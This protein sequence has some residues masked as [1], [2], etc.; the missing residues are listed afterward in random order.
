MGTALSRD[1]SGTYRELGHTSPKSTSGLAIQQL[2][3]PAPA[4]PAQGL[5]DRMP[6]GPQ[7]DDIGVALLRVVQWIEAG[8]RP[9]HELTSAVLADP[10]IT[11]KLIRAANIVAHVRGAAS[12]TTISKTIVLLGLDRVRVL[13][14]SSSLLE[15]LRDKDQAS[16]IHEE[17]ARSLYATTLARELAAGRPGF[18]PEE[19]AICTL[20][21]CFGRLTA[22]VYLYRPYEEAIALARSEGIAPTSAA[23]RTMGMGFER[24]GVELLNRWKLP[25]RIVQAVLPCPATLRTSATPQMV[26]RALGEFS[27]GT[28]DAVREPD[29]IARKRRL[30][31]LLDRFGPAL[32]L[33]RKRMRETL[34]VVD[35]RARELGQA[36]G[37]FGTGAAGN[38]LDDIDLMTL[39]PS[40]RPG[41]SLTLGAGV[42]ALS[43]MIERDEPLVAALDHAVGVLHR[44]FEF[45]RVVL[46]AKDAATQ[47]YSIR[48]TAGRLPRIA[49]HAFGFKE[50]MVSH[51]LLNAVVLQGA[52]IYIRD[53]TDPRVQKSLPAWF[54]AVCADARSFLLLPL[55]T[56]GESVGFLYADHARSNVQ[57]LTHEE[58]QL[59]KTLKQQVSV[60]LR[61]EQSNRSLASGAL[62]V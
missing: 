51:D 52:D 35:E 18:E 10:F 62:S 47:V 14:R 43:R 21:R 48:S 37:V 50:E 34:R 22:A 26:L 11:Q 28:A 57:R 3:T 39:S 1:Q 20:F 23:V 56:A 54:K 61:Q 40:N 33:T 8:E 46:C 4:T 41:A 36:L 27:A 49:E 12:V 25:E 32:G 7:L 6:A 60:A 42:I 31:A 29:L 15:S 9:M 13:A 38:C 5:L 16:R 59:I 30:E 19:A 55:A 24:L 17:F 2:P 44:A 45:Q 58:V 53:A